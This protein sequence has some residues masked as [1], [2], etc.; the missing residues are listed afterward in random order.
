L[1]SQYFKEEKNSEKVTEICE[2]LAL[3]NKTLEE[4]ERYISS[5]EFQR[6]RLSETK[7]KLLLEISNLRDELLALLPERL[8]NA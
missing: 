4:V 6:S 7:T 1:D 8:E 2:K 5:N 3:E